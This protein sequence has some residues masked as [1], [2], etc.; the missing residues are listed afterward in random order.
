RRRPVW[1]PNR[2]SAPPVKRYLRIPLQ[3]RKKK[4]R[5]NPIFLQISGF[6]LVFSKLWE[7]S[8]AD[9]TSDRKDLSRYSP[10]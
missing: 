10:R 6:S 5:E 8:V 2:A 3:T 1:R 7:N 9:P 4:I